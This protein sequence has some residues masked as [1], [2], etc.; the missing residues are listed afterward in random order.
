MFRNYILSTFLTFSFVFN[1]LCPISAALSQEVKIPAS[2][3]GS[4]LDS[5]LK[6]M[7]AGDD[8]PANKFN[9][10]GYLDKAESSIRNRR[11]FR[12]RARDLFGQL[13]LAKVVGEK[14]RE[15]TVVLTGRDEQ[16]LLVT[17]NLAPQPDDLIDSVMIKPYRGGDPANSSSL[18]SDAEVEASLTKLMERAVQEG[19]SGAVLLARGS[20]PLFAQAHGL[21]NRSYRIQNTINTKFNLGSMNKMFTAVAAMQLVEQKKLS[22]TDPVSNYLDE[23]WLPE[24]IT[25]R[26]QV[27]HLLNHTSGMGSYFNEQFQNGSRAKFRNL[28]DYKP[29]LKNQQLAF[30]PGTQW[31]YS[32]TGFLLLGAIL[33]KVTGE[34][35]YDYIRANV[36]ARANMPDTDSFELDIPTENLAYGYWQEDGHWKNNLFLHVIKGGPAGGGFSTLT[37]LLHFSVALTDGKLLSPETTRMTVSPKPESPR[38]GFGFESQKLPT[39]LVVG[40]SGGFPG[41]EANLSIFLDQGLTLVILCNAEGSMGLVL[42]DIRDI[43]SSMGS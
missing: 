36:Y 19:F 10:A 38:Y 37:D 40:H 3:V 27:R 13:T 9:P 12:D 6:F 15:I 14:D 43:V 26:I 39:G 16:K 11:E 7:G 22:L 25:S 30:E 29:L 31:Q 41:I 23:T 24:T 17:I 42:D 18:M 35:Y 34:N 5:W 2:R 20:E 4:V 8:S 21:A 32:N 33:E 1:C 28:V